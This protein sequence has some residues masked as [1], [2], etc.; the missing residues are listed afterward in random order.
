VARRLR[1]ANFP[2]DDRI[3]ALRAYFEQVGGAA[4]RAELYFSASSFPGY[5][6][7]FPTGPTTANV[8]VGMVLN[9]LPRSE[10]PLKVLLNEL[11]AKDTALR[12]RLESDGHVP[13]HVVFHVPRPFRAELPAGARVG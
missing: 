12:D 8:G 3:I 1:H 4:D 7:L 9:T 5:Y 10:Q 13:E 2:D 11:I 6:W